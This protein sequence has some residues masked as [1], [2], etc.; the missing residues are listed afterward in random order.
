MPIILEATLSSRITRFKNTLDPQGIRRIGKKAKGVLGSVVSGISWLAQKF[1]GLV[2][3]VFGNL[4]K[5][6][7]FSISSIFGFLVNSYYTL[8]TFNWNQT[9]EEINKRIQAN[10]QRCIDS[11]APLAGSALGWGTVR[12]VNMA[13]GKIGGALQAGK[14]PTPGISIPVLSGRIALA[15][16]EESRDEVGG[17][18]KAFLNTIQRAQTENAILGFLLTARNTGLFGWKPISAP[19]P[20]ASF[21]A[22]IDASIESLP[23]KWQNFAEEFIE[24]FEEAIIEAVYVVAFEADDYMLMMKKGLQN[25]NEDVKTFEVTVSPIQGA[26]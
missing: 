23:A 13:I 5:L 12:L 17:Q 22:K 11:L 2:G 21:Q 26:D 19:L 4:L 8:K 25:N 6:M 9:D 10:N 3:F 14:Q 24:S 16:A 18:F 1:S 15:L 7:P 20:N